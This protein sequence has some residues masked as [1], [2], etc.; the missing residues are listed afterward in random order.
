MN[1]L[2]LQKTTTSW[3]SFALPS[4]KDAIVALWWYEAILENKMKEFFEIVSFTPE[5][6]EELVSWFIDLRNSRLNIPNTFKTWEAE[7]LKMC[8]QE[9]QKEV[10]NG[11]T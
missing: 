5:K 10:S 3:W 6:I 11:V 8:I 9:L 4:S 1:Q 2:S 7:A